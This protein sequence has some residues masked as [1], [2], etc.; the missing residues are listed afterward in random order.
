MSWPDY[1]HAKHFGSGIYRPYSDFIGEVVDELDNL[2]SAE[3]PFA[4]ALVPYPSRDTILILGKSLAIFA[5]SSSSHRHHPLF[6]VAN[7]D[8]SWSVGEP[9]FV[10]ELGLDPTNVTHVKLPEVLAGL[11]QLFSLTKVVVIAM[12]AIFQ[13][14]LPEQV[15]VRARNV[16]DAAK[17]IWSIE[18][19]RYEELLEMDKPKDIFLSHKS[20]DKQIVREAARSLSAI[21]FSPWLDED[22]IRAGAN[23]ERALRDGFTRSCAAV[24]FV[25]SN[26]IDEG[27]LATE[28]DYALAEKREK[29][30]RFAI[31]TL[32]LRGLDGNFGTP[33]KM[34]N[35]YVWKEVE[36]GQVI[37]TIVESL[38]IKMD[39]VVWRE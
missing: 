8:E 27:F 36:A 16:S 28:I 35:Q 9:E 20:V 2:V 19:T 12:P 25:T 1:T 37:R 15:G 34:I 4:R 29:G 24:F 38:P 13:P 18:R 33:P 23:L 26:F 30:D 22:K 17:L 21:G 3:P 7:W 10:A 6:H 39:R 14:Q 11:E 31:V 32:L 5:I